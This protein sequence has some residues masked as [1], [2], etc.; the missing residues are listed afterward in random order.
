VICA[1]VVGHPVDPSPQA[2]TVIE[3]LQAAPQFDVHLLEQ[4][5]LPVW[6]GFIPADQAAHRLPVLSL[7]LNVEPI[8]ILG[9]QS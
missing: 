6:V 1:N 4:I 2:A 8:L 9:T 3:P 5:A 7:S